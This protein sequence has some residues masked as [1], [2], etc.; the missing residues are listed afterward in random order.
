MVAHEGKGFKAAVGDVW[1]NPDGIL[2]M[3][4]QRYPITDIGI[5][6]LVAKLIERA[7]RDK[8]ADPD[9]LTTEVRFTKGAKINGR[10]CMVIEVVH[11]EPRPHYDFHIAQ[12]FID[13]E[14]QVPVRYAAYTWPTVPGGKP[15][16]EEAYTYLDLKLNVGLSEDDFDHAK[17]FRK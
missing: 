10:G 4:G 6:N 3:H 1:L 2:A 5:E 7:T 8:N 11:A 17:K 13:D 16:L 12:V 9:A 15:Q 14:F